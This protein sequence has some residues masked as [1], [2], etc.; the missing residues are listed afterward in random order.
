MNM[1]VIQGGAAAARRR[2]LAWIH[3]AKAALGMAEA[4]YR[5]LLLRCTG[6]QSAARCSAAQRAAV[7]R[8]MARLG[9]RLPEQRAARSKAPLHGF[10]AQRL[11][12]H[13]WREAAEAGVVR[14]ASIRALLRL[15]ERVTGCRV[16]ALAWLPPA[17]C[18]RTIEAVKAMLSRA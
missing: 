3:M 5:A 12:Q 4:D 13:L 14:D 18:R 1:T 6:Q 7:L 8:E 16:A 9:W 11:L 17:E 2:E 10:N 15:A